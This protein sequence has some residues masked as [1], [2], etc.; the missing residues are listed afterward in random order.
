MQSK[1]TFGLKHVNHGMAVAMGMSAAVEISV[2]KGFAG[3]GLRDK[4]EEIFAMLKLPSKIPV[5][6]GQ[7]TDKTASAILEALSF[8]KKFSSGINKFVLLRDIGQP[9]ICEGI[10]SQVINAALKAIMIGEEE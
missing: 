5:K 10:E 9:F 6:S 8:D 1:K 3:T 7:G 2:M 4:L